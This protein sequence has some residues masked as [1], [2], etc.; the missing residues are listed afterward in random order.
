MARKSG[1][2]RYYARVLFMYSLSEDEYV[3]RR[4]FL[5]YCTTTEQRNAILRFRKNRKKW[6]KTYKRW[7]NENNKTLT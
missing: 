7:A 4:A 1:L 6:L 2:T 5:S 3:R